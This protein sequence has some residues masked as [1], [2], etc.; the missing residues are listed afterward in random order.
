MLNVANGG[1]EEKTP[2]TRFV[3]PTGSVRFNWAK[4]TTDQITPGP[5]QQP[6]DDLSVAVLPGSLKSGALAGRAAAN[7]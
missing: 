5:L 4:P 6:L 2:G 7:G 3:D 1:D